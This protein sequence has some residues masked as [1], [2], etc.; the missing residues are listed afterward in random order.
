MQVLGSLVTSI[1][2]A[3]TCDAF[4]SQTSI[5]KLLLEKQKGMGLSFCRREWERQEAVGEAGGSPAGAAF[6][7]PQLSFANNPYRLSK[8]MKKKEGDGGV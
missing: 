6:P 7:T 2:L 4:F 1:I 5:T 8:L 3:V